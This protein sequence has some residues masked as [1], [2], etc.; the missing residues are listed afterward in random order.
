MKLFMLW[1]LYISYRIAQIVTFPIWG[2][3]MLV[4]GIHNFFARIIWSGSITLGWLFSSNFWLFYLHG[5][6]QIFGDLLNDWLGSVSNWLAK[7]EFWNVYI[8]WVDL[9]Y[10]LLYPTALAYEFFVTHFP[11]VFVGAWAFGLLV[12]APYVIGAN[13]SDADF[14]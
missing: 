3:A 7:M 8:F 2:P 13:R 12:V 9:K 14:W 11:D 5:T 10:W 1:T 4:L 6:I